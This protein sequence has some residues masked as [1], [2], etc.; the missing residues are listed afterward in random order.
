MPTEEAAAAAAGATGGAKHVGRRL[1]RREDP[2]LIRGKGTFIDDVRLPGMLHMA[3][4]RSDL[5]HGRIVG[6]E[7]SVAESMPGVRLVVTGADLK[8]L[9]PTVPVMTPFP[10][11]EHHAVAPERVRYVGEP[12]AVVVA[13]D[14]YQARDALEA[15]EVEIEELPAVV[16]SERALEG[17]PTLVHEAFANN[18]ALRIISGTGVAEAGGT[19]DPSTVD[20]RALEAAFAEAEVVISQRMVNPRIAPSAIETRGV[21]A[22]Y[23]A[24]REYLTVWSTTQRPHA[25]RRFLAA[26]LGLGEQ[27]ARTIAPDMGGGFGA[28]KI[29]GEDFVAAALSK[30]LGAPVKWIEDRSEAFLTTTHARDVVGYIELAA[31]R[32]G[33]VL[34]LKA[35]LIA[36]IGAYEMLLT[37]FI[38]TLT[39][40]LLSGGYAIPVIRSELIEV[41]T[42]KMPTDAYRGAGMPEAIF[43][44]E[45]SME[46]LARELGMDPAEVR[47]RNFIQP[48][49]FPYQTA[50]G[51]VYDSG[52]YER[53]LDK[54][55]AMANWEERRAEQ[56]AAR[57]EGRLVGLGMSFYIELCAIG[58]STM[59]PDGGWE[60]G[61]VTVERD[62][63]ITA[64]TGAS[65]HGQGHETTFA[66]VLADQFGVEPGAIRLL[67][68]DTA[69][70]K[71][72]VGTVASRS[73]VVGGTALLLAG[74]KVKVKM[75]K[76]A[77]QLLEAREEAITFDAGSV[78]VGG[79]GRLSFA[80]VAAYAYSPQQLP[81]GVEPGLSEEA[82]WEPTGMTFPYGCYVA[83]V[84]VDRETGEV[85]LQRFVGV[86]DCG[87]IVNPLIVEGQIHGGI[88]QG[89]GP[90]LT[91]ELV[92]DE[93]GQLLTGS[94]MDYAIPRASDL[95]RFELGVT[96]TPSPLNPLGAKGTGEAGTIGATPAVL[97]AVV[98]ALSDLG[99]KHIDPTLGAEKLWRLIHH[100]ESGQVLGS[101][102]EPVGRQEIESR[103]D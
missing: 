64:T 92:Y 19:L 65:A 54:T 46:L 14:R 75:A 16:D 1:K 44:V 77:A 45:R 20:D 86:D 102:E 88:A 71:Q 59:F 55:L 53:L 40:G 96:V 13:E 26:A 28:K 78:G 21:V 100:A 56:A 90:A 47:R 17:E 82:F 76:F 41:F 18:V 31:K 6:I 32:D 95:P 79:A 7:T 37:A 68:G 74:E 99:V 70:A 66:Q 85:D 98:D 5:A 67:H 97:N 2:A 49:Q 89:I 57:K 52:E 29:Y 58:P 51:N 22:Q 34:A 81:A 24:A 9:L 61:S 25:H 94:F 101:R 60:Y 62:G 103:N 4:K 12:V 72:G 8:E 30:Q 83:Q 91:E 84:E 87:T 33:T 50:A 42:N 39:H 73:L 69:V 93:Q 23:E 35:R 80:E 63:G 36:D 27:Q 38:P 3:F 10:Y 48:E 15:I 11:P 43:F